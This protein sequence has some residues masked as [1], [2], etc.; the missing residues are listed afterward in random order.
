MSDLRVFNRNQTLVA[1][2]LDTL[3]GQ[4]LDLNVLS[5]YPNVHVWFFFRHAIQL[6]AAAEFSFRA[7]FFQVPSYEGDSA[8]YVQKSVIFEA[9]RNEEYAKV[10]F[11]TG[12]ADAYRSALD[13]L[14]RQGI[15]VEVLHPSGN[16]LASGT[17]HASPV[18]VASPVFGSPVL[19]GAQAISTP[20]YGMVA[21]PA[22][23]ANVMRIKPSVK[24]RHRRMDMPADRDTMR[25]V[26]DALLASWELGE[27]I[28][29]TQ[30]SPLIHR[31]TGRKVKDLFKHNNLSSFYRYL[32]NQEIIEPVDGEKAFR[33]LS[34]EW[35][36][37]ER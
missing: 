1:L 23:D 24:R 22:P 12:H 30:L 11:L 27:V 25:L 31:G 18:A 3:G 37:P 21:A 16:T 13:F 34:K 33:V 32:L 8:S 14:G 4:G 9:G 26:M 10:L 35:E 17:S 29:R 28:S 20:S 6:H 15:D 5:K 7:A 19:G 2:D 36:M